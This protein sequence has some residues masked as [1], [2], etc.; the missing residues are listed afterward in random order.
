MDRFMRKE[1]SKRVAY[2]GLTESK[3]CKLNIFKY[4]LSYKNS[5]EDNVALALEDLEYNIKWLN[6]TYNNGLKIFIVIKV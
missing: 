5:S 2:L 1:L 4:I 6:R 3:T